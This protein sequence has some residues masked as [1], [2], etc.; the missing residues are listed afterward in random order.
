MGA[1]PGFR[2]SVISVIMIDNHLFSSG[3][4]NYM[5][6]SAQGVV[7]GMATVTSSSTG[8]PTG[9]SLLYILVHF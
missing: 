5:R 3:G 4:S 6:V 2:I 7:V 8:A 1:Q 9:A